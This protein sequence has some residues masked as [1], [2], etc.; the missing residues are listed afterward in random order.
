MCSIQLTFAI[1]RQRKNGKDGW[2]LVNGH[3]RR[4]SSLS[5][6]IANPQITV[7]SK[8]MALWSTL[9]SYRGIRIKDMGPDAFK[10][11]EDELERFLS[12]SG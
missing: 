8:R 6:T 11:D 9:T 4:V 2:K 10:T 7:Q 5:I 3:F 1:V 12:R